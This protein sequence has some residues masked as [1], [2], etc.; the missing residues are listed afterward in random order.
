MFD[1]GMAEL[2]VIGIVAL[3]VVGPKD[4]PV[5]FRRVGQFV[6][7]AKGMAREFSSAMNQ[8][9]D[10]AGVKDVTDTFK[11]ATDGL[12]T[13]TNP[14]KAATETFKETT[15]TIT[16][17]NIDPDSETG[18]LAAQRAEDTRKIQ[19]ATAKKAQERLEA[20]AKAAEKAAAE[21]R[22]LADAAQQPAADAA[23]KDKA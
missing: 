9:A 14:M 2:L 18:K 8:A 20:D 11:S 22:A 7:K 10:Q 1:L 4:L 17:L 5:L 21:A 13:V 6:G 19:E 12:N 3:I 15:K 23:E 16:D